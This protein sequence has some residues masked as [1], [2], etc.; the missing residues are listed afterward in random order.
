MKEG[1]GY[2]IIEGENGQPREISEEDFAKMAKDGGEA[3]DKF[4]E[5]IEQRVGEKRAGA[6]PEQNQTFRIGDMLT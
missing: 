5:R 3:M 6:T 1:K 2:F 4:K